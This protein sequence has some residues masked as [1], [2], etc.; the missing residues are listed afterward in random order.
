MDYEWPGNIRELE[1][2]IQGA[3]ILADGDSLTCSDLPEF[4][5]PTADNGIARA[6]N[7]D[8]E[9]FETLLQ[10]FKVNLARRY[11]APHQ[12]IWDTSDFD[13]RKLADD[14]YLLTYTLLQ[15]KAMF[16]SDF[17]VITPDRWLRDAENVAFREEVKPKIMLENAKKL[18]KLDI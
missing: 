5:Q 16:G 9:G 13:C 4:M 12:D 14:V 10:N 3:V 6:D 1:N 2:V 17:P 8:S 15:N 11:A 18:L 7:S